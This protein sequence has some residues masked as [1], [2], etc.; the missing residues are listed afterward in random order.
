AGSKDRPF[1]GVFV[2]GQNRI[3]DRLRL[4]ARPRRACFVDILSDN[5]RQYGRKHRNDA[6][7][8][9]HFDES[10]SSLH[11]YG[12]VNVFDEPSLKLIVKAT[13]DGL[14][15]TPVPV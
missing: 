9:N 11:V 5:R 8:D 4:L 14:T 7:N 10:E 1:A 12:T 2:E 3:G 13:P 6:E 15:A